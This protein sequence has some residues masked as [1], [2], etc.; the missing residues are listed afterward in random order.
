MKLSI[1]ALS[2]LILAGAV[3]STAIGDGNHDAESA[4]AA[5]KA[6]QAQMTLY[7]FNI[8]VLGGM[9]KG[10]TDYDAAT[11]S[12]AAS[13]LATLATLDQSR[14]WPPGSDNFELGGE[15][16]AA[17]PAI[18]A[19][20]SD[21]GAKGMA[22][23]EAAAAMNGAAGNGLEALRGAMGAL[24]NSCGGCHKAYRQSKN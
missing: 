7:A 9:A 24:G 21:I 3:A 17:L 18:W 10:E 16:T 23:A 8:G 11:A 20:D 15:V 22:F 2:G 1:A 12:K 4:K 13:N 5:I 6:R 14:M 19:A